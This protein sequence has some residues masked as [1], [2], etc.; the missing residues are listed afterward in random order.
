[1]AVKLCLNLRYQRHHF[2]VPHHIEKM[3]IKS[4]WKKKKSSK[5]VDFQF[6]MKLVISIHSFPKTVRNS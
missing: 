1:M 5:K 2:R 4:I 6:S 3:E